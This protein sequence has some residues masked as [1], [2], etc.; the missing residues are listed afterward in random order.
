MF[1]LS[2]IHI[3]TTLFIILYWNNLDGASKDELFYLV[4]IGY[5]AGILFFAHKIS[6]LST[7]L[8]SLKGE[9]QESVKSS[10]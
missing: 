8:A 3:I 1:K 7:E 6:K 5:Q 10:V 9:G 4:I 2:I